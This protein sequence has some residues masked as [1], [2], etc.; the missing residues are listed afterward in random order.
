LARTVRE[1]AELQALYSIAIL[2]RMGNISVERLRR[3]LRSA[4]VVLIR[5]GRAL[6]VPLSEVQRKIPPLWESLV[7]TEQVRRGGRTARDTV[8]GG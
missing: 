7:L 5:G 4:G 6:F 3:V 2:A 8:G 1:T